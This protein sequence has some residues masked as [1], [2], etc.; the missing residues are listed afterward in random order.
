[1]I[2]SQLLHALSTNCA[3]RAFHINYITHRDWVPSEISSRALATRDPQV[4]SHS[5]QVHP[6]ARAASCVSCTRSQGY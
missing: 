3:L 4:R 1:M 6:P 5:S 2:I